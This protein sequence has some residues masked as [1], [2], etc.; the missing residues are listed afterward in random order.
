[1]AAAERTPLLYICS[2]SDNNKMTTHSCLSEFDSK[3][4]NMLSSDYTG[5]RQLNDD[6]PVLKMSLPQMRKICRN[7]VK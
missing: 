3:S 1:M 7:R 2:H 5:Y 6:S 4:L